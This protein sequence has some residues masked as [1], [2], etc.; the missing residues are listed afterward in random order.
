[1][2]EFS[3]NINESLPTVLS[4]EKVT[5]LSDILSANDENLSSVLEKVDEP[6]GGPENQ[7]STF[8]AFS[9]KNV[10]KESFLNSD[11]TVFKSETSIITSGIS[12][13]PN[14]T[15]SASDF[16]QNEVYLSNDINNFATATAEVA[17]TFDAF[18]SKFDKAAEVLS[19]TTGSLCDPFVNSS[20]AM[21]TSSDGKITIMIQHQYL[22][23]FLPAL[24]CWK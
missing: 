3:V 7:S 9:P 11:E 14:F 5:T 22:A 4:D 13:S 21:D 23:N 12:Q 16:S 15:A 8:T 6:F 18:A 19:T 2:P 20:T 1:M 24:P 17:D 10:S